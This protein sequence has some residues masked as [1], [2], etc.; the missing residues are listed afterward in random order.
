MLV[1]NGHRAEKI[2]KGRY[3]VT[4]PHADGLGETLRA[5]SVRPRGRLRLVVTD[6]IRRDDEPRQREQRTFWPIAPGAAR[7][8]MIHHRNLAT[9][10]VSP[11]DVLV[12]GVKK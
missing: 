11:A 5:F 4:S 8:D 9:G 6:V 12:N 3:E 10:E 7:V 1:T 2:A